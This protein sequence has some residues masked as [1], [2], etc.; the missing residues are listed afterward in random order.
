MFWVKSLMKPSVDDGK[1]FEQC[2][3]EYSCLGTILFRSFIWVA[4]I[5]RGKISKIIQSV[6]NHGAVWELVVWLPGDIAQR[7][8]G[9]I[10]HCPAQ[11]TPCP[12]LSPEMSHC[13]TTCHQL[14]KRGILCCELPCSG[15]IAARSPETGLCFWCWWSQSWTSARSLCWSSPLCSEPLSVWVQNQQSL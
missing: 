9:L 11:V 3:D 7:D 6:H 5:I 2:C 15:E 14:I 13:L 1:L 8:A 12:C 10:C 4:S